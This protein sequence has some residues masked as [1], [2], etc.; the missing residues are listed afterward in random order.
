METIKLDISTSLLPKNLA[1]C[2]G[3]FDGCHIGHKALIEEVKAKAKA[4]N[5]KSGLM[6]FFPHPG[7]V[8]EKKTYRKVITPLNVKEELAADFGLDYFIVV[9]FDL[10][11]AN[12]AYD[13]FYERY[14]SQITYLVIGADFHFGRF[15]LGS[16]AYLKKIHHAVSVVPLLK[17]KG[18]KISSGL[19]IKYLLAGNI[20]LANMMLG[21]C[22]RIS[23][24]YI[25]QMKTRHDVCSF[26]AKPNK[27]YVDLMQGSYVIEARIH[28]QIYQG[29][30]NIKMN[31]MIDMKYETVC[32]LFIY[33]FNDSIANEVI[34]YFHKFL[35]KEKHLKSAVAM[36]K[37]MQNDLKQVNLYFGGEV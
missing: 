15:S 28:R 18:K 12:L 11:F 23:C 10:S 5:L 6:T 24:S 25:N 31:Q 22:Y 36:N 19:I 4:F 7:I 34:V 29:L 3:E 14:L 30:A 13:L 33:D 16:A 26:V 32:E 27:E 17:Y 9:Q 37:Q 2:I 35:H 20:D 21:R 8:L 1:V